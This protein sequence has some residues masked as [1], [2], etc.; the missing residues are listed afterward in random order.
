MTRKSVYALLLGAAVVAGGCQKKDV[1]PAAAAPSASPSVV[2]GATMTEDEKAILAFGAAVGQQVAQQVKPLNLSPAE[3]ETLKKAFLASL[4]GEKPQYDI[5]QYGALLSARAQK[6]S[7]TVAAGEKEKA[8]GF[9]ES[10][11][12]VPGAV[13][14]ASG[15]IYRTITPGTGPSPKATDTVSVHYHGTLPDG[16]VFDSSVQRGQPVEFPLNQV[17]PCWTEGVQRMRV[18][19]KA[20]L[21]CPSEIAYGDGGR[22]PDIPPGATLVFEVELLAIKGK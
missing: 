19:E 20:R 3:M 1:A 18:G 16:K 7:A 12:A 14:T 21:V 5:Q 13:K 15:L 6:Q 17:I 8:A 9:R 22:G 4:A 2:P 10:A 11:A